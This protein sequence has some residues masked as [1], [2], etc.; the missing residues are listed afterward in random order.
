MDESSTTVAP[1]DDSTVDTAEVIGQA[2]DVI[3]Q[4]AETI[5]EEKQ[6]LKAEIKE[7]LKKPE[8]VP[9]VVVE[10]P[11]RVIDE[12]VH[13]IEQIQPTEDDEKRVV[14]EQIQKELEVP[15]PQ[16]VEPELAVPK[17]QTSK[18]VDNQMIA[19]TNRVLQ[20][21][22]E[23]LLAAANIVNTDRLNKAREKSLDARHA[24]EQ[25]HLD[26]VYNFIKSQI[27]TTPHSV[28][29][30][31]DLNPKKV[32]R[33]VSKLVDQH[34]ITVHGHGSSTKYKIA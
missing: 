20:L 10:P 21:T 23:E 24:I 1:V 26:K 6:E 4:Q 33:L 32:T 2:E 11:T 31:V 16:P 5:K 19:P 34:K 17:P 25:E 7:E 14:A 28:A 15:A 27:E 8:E 12:A 29:V 3:E 22:P 18:S 30:G 9:A 13:T